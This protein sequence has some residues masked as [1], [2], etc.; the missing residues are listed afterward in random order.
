MRQTRKIASNAEENERVRR[1]ISEA[2]F[3]LLMEKDFS[4]ITVTDIIQKAGVARASYYRNF[5]SKKDV[6]RQGMETIHDMVMEGID[7]E[8]DGPVPRAQL[9]QSL[10][11]LFT[12][13]LSVKSYV[14][15]LY[16][17]GFADMFQNLL[18]E[19]AESLFGSMP[20]K[21]ME[22]YRIYCFSGAI[23]NILITWLKN[24]AQ[25]SPH[26]MAQFCLNLFPQLP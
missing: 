8:L 12:V 19:Y 25:E 22:K 2:L 18:D 13:F 7:P 5:Q 4:A 10:E 20:Q 16:R 6:L 24:G 23:C 11:R 14:L 15:T 9:G 3:D 26:A 21:S 17:A 1:A